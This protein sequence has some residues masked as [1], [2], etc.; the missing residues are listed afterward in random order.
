MSFDVGA[1]WWMK[2]LLDFLELIICF[3]VCQYLISFG[4]HWKY[5]YKM[6]PLQEISLR[7]SGCPGYQSCDV[8]SVRVKKNAMRASASQRGALARE[9]LDAPVKP[10]PK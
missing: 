3:F 4:V 8:G 9:F 10:R 1:C 2:K 5:F 6:I 7:D